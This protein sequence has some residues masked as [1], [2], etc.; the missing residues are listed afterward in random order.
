[1]GMEDDLRQAKGCVVVIGIFVVLLIIA[2]I[3]LSILLAAAQVEI[4]GG[5]RDAAPTG[6]GLNFSLQLQ[7]NNG[8]GF[9]VQLGGQYGVLRAVPLPAPL[10]VE[11]A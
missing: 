7:F 1:M 6:G 4:V 9:A 11:G 10:D 2:V 3:V 8:G 5:F